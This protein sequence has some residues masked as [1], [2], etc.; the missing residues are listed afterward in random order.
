[1]KVVEKEGYT[2]LGIVELDKVKEI[3]MKETNEYKRRLQVVVKSKLNGKI[4]ITAVSAWAEALF[5]NTTMEREWIE[6]CGLEIKKNNDNVWSVTPEERCWQILRKK[7]RGR[8][9][10][11]EC[12]TLR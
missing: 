1:M 8:Q 5:R 11:D 6:S 7:E 3:E 12:G 10:S 2:Y 9:K 4:K